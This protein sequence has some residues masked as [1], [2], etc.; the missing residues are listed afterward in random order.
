MC[1]PLKNIKN[2]EYRVEIVKRKALRHLIVS[3]V[4]YFLQRMRHWTQQHA[5]QQ[6][7]PCS[8]A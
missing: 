6:R 5:N 1:L 7:S 3:N 2:V 8:G 4:A